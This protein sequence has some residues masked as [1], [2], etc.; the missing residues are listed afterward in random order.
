[1]AS[2][3]PRMTVIRNTLAW[4]TTAWV[5]EKVYLIYTDATI[6]LDQVAAHYL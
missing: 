2:V 6:L 5:K 3:P 4:I 1:M